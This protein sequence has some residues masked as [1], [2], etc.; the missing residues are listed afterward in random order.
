[1]GRVVLSNELRDRILHNVTA[2]YNEMA[3]KCETDFFAA[4]ADRIYRC[5][6]SEETENAALQLPPAL[7][8]SGETIY[9]KRKDFRYGVPLGR[10]RP[11]PQHLQYVY[12]NEIVP[13]TDGVLEQEISEMEAAVKELKEKAAKLYADVKK[14]LTTCKTLKQVIEVWPSVLEFC[15]DATKARH[16]APDPPRYKKGNVTLSDDTKLELVKVRML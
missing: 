15:P 9:F 8:H 11:L 13:I 3:E 5:I 12:N 2:K 10:S 7:V 6:V 16:A 1:M 14:I 4:N